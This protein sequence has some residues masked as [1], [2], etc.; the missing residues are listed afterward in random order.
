MSNTWIIDLRHYLTPVGTLAGL[1]GPGRI[2]ADYWTKIVA[3]GSNFDKPAT[4]RCR[5]RPGH[6]VCVGTLDIGLDPSDLDSII[7]CCPSCGDNGV[8]RGWRGTFWDNSD[9]PQFRRHAS[10][11]RSRDRR[12]LL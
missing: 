10:H 5:R 1:P 3:Q 6:R 2:L 8:I 12:P 7:W 11:P 4:L 9:P